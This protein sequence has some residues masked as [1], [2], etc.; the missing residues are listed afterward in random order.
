MEPEISLVFT[1][2]SHPGIPNENMLGRIVI[3]AFVS[4]VPLVF[5]DVS[6]ATT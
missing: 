1:R 3:F 5:Y 4:I 2:A 6:W